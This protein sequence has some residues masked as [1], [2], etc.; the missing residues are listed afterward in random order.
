MPR[1]IESAFWISFFPFIS[2]WMSATNQWSQENI[3]LPTINLLSTTVLVFISVEMITTIRNLS[4][5][6]EFQV[7]FLCFTV[8]LIFFTLTKSIAR[9]LLFSIFLS[10]SFSLALSLALPLSSYLFSLSLSLFLSLALSHWVFFI[11]E[12]FSNLLE[13]KAKNSTHHLWNKNEEIRYYF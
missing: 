10:F 4:F 7:F 9:S 5:L 3:I 2:L 1:S 6:S 13:F 11:A 12:I 8:F